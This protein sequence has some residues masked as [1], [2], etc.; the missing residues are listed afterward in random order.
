MSEQT[1]QV[2]TKIGISV[3]LNGGKKEMNSATIPIEWWFS[4]EIIEKDPKY[5]VFFEQD[6]DGKKTNTIATSMAVG[7]PAK[8][9]M[10]SNICNYFRLVIIG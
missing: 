2:D 8:S 1:K 6:E 5:I 9:W 10:L 3:V 7:M 4:K